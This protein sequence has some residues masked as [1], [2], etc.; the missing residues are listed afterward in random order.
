MSYNNISTREKSIKKMMSLLNTDSY[1]ID[2][3]IFYCKYESDNDI[4]SFGN[5]L[6]NYRDYFEQFLVTADIPESMYYQPAAFAE[7]YYGTPDLDFLVLYFA[8]MVS[9]YDFKKPTIKVL[10]RGKLLE[11]NRLFIEYKAAVDGSYK[12]P[13]GYIDNEI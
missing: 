12:N 2:K 10:P 7:S 4:V 13:T 3:S 1:T 5:V 11:V 8:K 6:D 9:L